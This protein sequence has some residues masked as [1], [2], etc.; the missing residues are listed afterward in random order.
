MIDTGSV[1]RLLHARS[2]L[3]R[4]E[5]DVLEAECDFAIDDVVN[6][7]KLWILEDEAHISRDMPGRSGDYVMPHHRCTAGDPPPVEMWDQAVENPEERRLSA[8][9][10][11][12][13]HCQ[14]IADLEADVAQRG[15]SRARI[16]VGQAT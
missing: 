1:Q 15:V 12:R 9:G 2:H 16:R 6:G 5:S 13:D 14:P 4:R 3:A 10:G 7:L 8:T 11:T